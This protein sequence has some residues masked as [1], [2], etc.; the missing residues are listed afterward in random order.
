MYYLEAACGFVKKK[1][2]VLRRAAGQTHPDATPPLGNISP[3]NINR[4][5]F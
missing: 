1:T 4:R 3:V 2:S 5:N